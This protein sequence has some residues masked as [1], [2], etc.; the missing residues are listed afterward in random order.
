MTRC[1][2]C[3][4]QLAVGETVLEA[5][6]RYFH[7][8]CLRC[9]CCNES[10]QTGRFRPVANVY[11]VCRRCWMVKSN[12]KIETENVK[13]QKQTAERRRTNIWDHHDKGEPKKSATSPHRKNA[14]AVDLVC[15]RCNEKIQSGIPYVY[16]AGYPL[17]ASCLACTVCSVSLVDS[18]FTIRNNNF[19]CLEHATLLQSD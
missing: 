4:G 9:S 18:K 10:I 3:K 2:R 6:G 5:C 15:Q 16:V 19:F 7:F 11:P 14:Q 1:G 17:H 13:K 8:D 12:K